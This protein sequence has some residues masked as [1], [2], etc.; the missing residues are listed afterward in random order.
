MKR[1]FL[2]TSIISFLF[3]F[4]AW[5]QER[6]EIEVAGMHQTQW[7][8]PALKQTAL[9]PTSG[10]QVY[11]R[12]V[13]EGNYAQA[14]VKSQQAH[15]DYRQQGNNNYINFDVQAPHVEHVV[16]QTGNSNRAFGFMTAEDQSNLQLLQSGNNQHFEQFGSN[17]IGDKMQVKMSGNTHAVIV[18]NF[19]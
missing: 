15:V 6:S 10:S 11:I 17:S 3:L 7:N 5:S 18:R 16:H 19:Q 2:L 12:Q 4:P 13:G 8:A 9:N 1:K 14:Q